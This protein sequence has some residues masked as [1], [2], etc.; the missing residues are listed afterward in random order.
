MKLFKSLLVAP[1]TLG[2][3]APITATAT[4]V[5]FNAISNYS[6]EEIEIDSNSFSNFSNA[7]PLL[8][9][10]EGMV[11]SH[12]HD[13]DSFSETTTASFSADF[14]I[15]AVDG[16]GVSTTVTDGDEDLQAVY[17]FQIDLTTSFT[18]EDSLDIS[19][20]AGNGVT[21]SGSLT[22]P[23][24]EFDLN[25]GG[26]SLSVDGVSYT[27]P[28]GS[29]T[30]VIVGDNTDG[31]AMFTTACAYGGPS[32]TLD[33]CANVNAGITNG[34]LAVGASFDIGNGFTA[35]LGY[36]G[37][38]QGLMTKEK[39]DAYGANVAYSADNYGVSV[40]YGV[41]ERDQEEDTYTAF[42]GYYSFDNGV[43]I[44][45]GYE[46]GDLGGKAASADET[47]AY[48]LGI[49][50]EVGPGELGAA[51]GTVGSMTETSTGIPERMMYEAYYS[52]ALNDGMTVT[53]LIYVKEGEAATDNDETGVMV[54]TS[55]SF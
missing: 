26:D 34:G 40:T 12:D 46:V 32:N 42:N 55:F 3:L 28:V 45:A 8:A 38:E 27:F 36:A 51:I 50:G 7:N 18:G 16:K 29:K 11:D 21:S 19:L 30:T 6:Q 5:N 48:F 15:G 44:S 13:S 22:G 33:D 52:Y 10:G 43:S 4:E 25:G 20:D 9:G 39:V 37:D 47:E 53:P 54:K 2:L 24:A 17:G 23:L 41:L 35:A 1:A 49:N 14:A 31:S